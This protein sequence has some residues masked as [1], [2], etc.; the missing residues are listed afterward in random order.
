MS[1]HNKALRE[2]KETQIL[3]AYLIHHDLDFDDIKNFSAKTV[4]IAVDW[5]KDQ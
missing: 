4:K 2:I 3:V 1:K 5:H